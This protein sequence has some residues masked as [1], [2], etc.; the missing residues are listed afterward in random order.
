MI[1]ILYLS[2][3][4]KCISED[5]KWKCELNNAAKQE[6]KRY[7]STVS[8]AN[9]FFILYSL[10][11][12]LSS[13]TV[14]QTKYELSITL[15]WNFKIIQLFEFYYWNIQSFLCKF[16]KIVLKITT[17]NTINKLIYSFLW[18]AILHKHKFSK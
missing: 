4:R 17:I 15:I 13:T 5:L 16:K 6:I 1:V 10:Y 14:N 7:S 3:S 18:F 11:E 12:F 2:D 9:K 8:N